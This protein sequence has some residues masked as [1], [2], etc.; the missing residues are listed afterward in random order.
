MRL[1]IDDAVAVGP[2]N[3]FGETPIVSAGSV[4]VRTPRGGVVA[5]P[6]DFNPERVMLDDVLVPLPSANVGDRYDGAVVGVLDYNFGNFFLEATGP[7]S[8]VP[9]GVAPETTAPAGAGQLAVATFN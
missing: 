4:S 5:R 7:V 6:G 2:T 3:A 1:E 9:G 8:V